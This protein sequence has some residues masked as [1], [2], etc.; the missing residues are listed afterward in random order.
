MESKRG[1][2]VE[3]LVPRFDL[4]IEPNKWS[5]Y[6]LRLYFSITDDKHPCEYGSAILCYL[7]QIITLRTTLSFRNAFAISLS[8]CPAAEDDGLSP[9]ERLLDLHKIPPEE[10]AT[11]QAR[12]STN[13][14]KP[15]VWY[16]ARNR[17]APL[18]RHIPM[19]RSPKPCG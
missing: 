9:S 15:E 4:R 5:L 6:I 17:T 3:S 10:F 13:G 2:N 7:S 12:T 16:S 14:E 1:K 18:S 8:P 19:R 11:N